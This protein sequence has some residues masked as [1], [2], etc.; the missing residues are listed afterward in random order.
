MP[1]HIFFF[2]AVTLCIN[3]V[4]FKLL[5]KQWNQFPARMEPLRLNLRCNVTNLNDMEPLIGI[6]PP[7]SIRE[8][9]DRL[10]EG[11]LAQL[12]ENQLIMTPA[13]TD[14]HQRILHTISVRI[15]N[16]LEKNPIGLVRIAPY[17]VF[18]DEQNVFQ[19]DIIFIKNEKTNS[20]RSDGLHTTPDLVIEILSPSSFQYDLHQKKDVY[21]R[22]GITEYWVV[23]PLTKEVQGYMLEAGRYG[24][25]LLSTEEFKSEVLGTSIKFH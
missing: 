16:Y 11:T 6:L 19:P 9:F 20:I 22:F 1:G 17:D 14:N 2:I 3:C 23:D 4:R 13:P 7:R 25:P 12:I 24:S 10:P 18:L 8:V 21:E 5:G 15:F